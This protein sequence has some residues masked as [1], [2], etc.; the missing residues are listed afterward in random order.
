MRM[1]TG[2]LTSDHRASWGKVLDVMSSGWR[3][4]M[5]ASR[6]R[7]FTRQRILSTSCRTDLGQRCWGSVPI[8]E[9]PNSAEIWF[10]PLS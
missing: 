4:A 5:F 3:A 6:R 2:V 8:S 1:G 9:H 7:A 10:W